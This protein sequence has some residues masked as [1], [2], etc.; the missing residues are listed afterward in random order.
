WGQLG[1][2]WGGATKGRLWELGLRG[3]HAG[4]QLVVDLGR[5]ASAESGEERLGGLGQVSGGVDAEQFLPV[6]VAVI[7]AGEVDR[8]CGSFRAAV[9]RI[10]FL[11]RAFSV[12]PEGIEA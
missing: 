12:R 3:L 6:G 9:P 5:H 11:I 10:T 8:V 7:S 2:G 4:A 1:A